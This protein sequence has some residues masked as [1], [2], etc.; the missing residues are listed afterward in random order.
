MDELD[1][2]FIE[3]WKNIDFTEW[4]EPDVREEFIAPLLRHL[5]YSS[6]TVNRIFRE[7]SL[8]L[9]RAYHRIGR[10]KIKIDYLP[11][12]RLKRFW[13][14]EAKPGTS[15][16]LGEGDFLQAHLYAIHPEI[17]AAYVCLCNG[18]EIRVYDVSA[19]TDW[20]D[21]ILQVDQTN[22]D[23]QF[24]ELKSLL[25]CRSI[26]GR[27]RERILSTI[28]RTL[29]AEVDEREVRRFASDASTVARESLKTVRAN[30]RGMTLAS[31]REASEQ[32]KKE[33]RDAGMG[34]LLSR[35]NV[36]TDGRPVVPK[37]ILSRITKADRCG[38]ASILDDVI[39]RYRGRPH[40]V[41][42]VLSA[43]VFSGVVAEELKCGK[44]E[45]CKSPLDGLDEIAAHNMTYW[46][47]NGLQ[48]ALCHLDN[49]CLRVAKKLA[50]RMFL[51]RVT[52]VIEAIKRT[53]APQDLLRN[54]PSVGREMVGLFGLL[55]ESMW[56]KFSRASSAEAIW[57]GIWAYEEL[58]RLAERI[59]APSYP[60]GEADLLFFEYYGRGSDMLCLG[61]WS[62]VDRL[63]RNVPADGLP[64][65]VKRVLSMSREDM[66]K[67]I[68]PPKR[69][70]DGWHPSPGES[71]LLKQAMDDLH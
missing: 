59:P 53:M 16:E 42:R 13:I 65:S 15:R 1:R 8:D 50:L 41:F 4:N 60:K 24:D 39:K 7:T 6:T 37:E 10:D 48:S 23:S 14:L 54:R 19:S 67:S 12:L 3:R 34:E 22:C 45:Y 21:Y 9:N 38:R 18:W 33:L 27:L 29:E 47:G 52:A 69:P 46:S 62:V 66:L 61:T 36:T 49:T 57:Q 70:P 26:L 44:G 32:E 2:Q 40:N 30:A 71:D 35:L 5:G 17:Q 25:S 63:L 64:D 58:E 28:Q 51:P 43:Y 11:T 68:P 55:S 20:D 31:L 56:R